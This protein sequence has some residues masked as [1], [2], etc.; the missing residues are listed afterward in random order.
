MISEATGQIVYKRDLNNAMYLTE[1]ATNFFLGKDGQIY[2]VY[3]YG[4]NNVTSEIDIIK[5]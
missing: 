4:N 3:A 2:I 1:N 5:L